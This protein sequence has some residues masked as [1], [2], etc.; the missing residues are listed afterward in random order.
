M[1]GPNN[2]TRAV[3]TQRRKRLEAALVC[4]HCAIENKPGKTYIEIDEQT[5][6]AWCS[7]CSKSFSVEH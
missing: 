2:Y 4:P 7:C 1:T 3:Q 5:G 6:T